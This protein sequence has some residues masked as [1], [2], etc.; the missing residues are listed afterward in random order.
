VE[1]SKRIGAS[2]WV[3]FIWLYQKPRSLNLYGSVHRIWILL[4]QAY[5]AVA[6]VM[7]SVFTGSVFFRIM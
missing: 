1:G 6:V 5:Q 2:R 3:H 4:D 7:D